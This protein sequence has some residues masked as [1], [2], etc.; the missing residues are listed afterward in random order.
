VFGSGKNI[1]YNIGY[2]YFKTDGISE[3]KDVS[4][5]GGFDKDGA[6]QNSF[7]LNLGFRP[8]ANL[9]IKPFLRYN[10]FDGKFDAGAL[11]DDL[12]NNFKTNLFNWGSSGAYALKKGAVNFLYGNE[13]SDRTYDGTYGE[14][15][16]KGRFQNAEV[17]LNYNFTIRFNCL[18]V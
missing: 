4:G 14:S 7:Q 3:A 1:D 13:S 9:S 5:A 12:Q 6:T 18:R 16:Y 2:G 10:D 15:K 11:T 17:F 8:I